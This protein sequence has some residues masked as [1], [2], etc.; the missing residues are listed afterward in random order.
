MTGLE[1]KIALVTGGSGGLGRALAH[2]FAA[3]GCRVVVTA[4]D[5]VKLNATAAE[6]ATN[7]RQVLAL[8]C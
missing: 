6:I 5:A 7:G 4:R 3:Q 8:P 1:Q 2:G